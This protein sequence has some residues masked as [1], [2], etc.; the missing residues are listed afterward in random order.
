MT[1]KGLHYLILI[2]SAVLLLLNLIFA[3]KWDLGFYLRA[4][5]N[6]LIIVA[7][8]VTINYNAKNEEGSK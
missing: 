6:V 4:V 1:K 2:T 5:S 7:M 8:V 3:E